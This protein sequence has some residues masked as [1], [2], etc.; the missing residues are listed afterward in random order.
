MQAAFEQLLQPGMCVYDVGANVG[1]FSVIAARLVGPEGCVI[2]FEPLPANARQIERNADLNHLGHIQVQT[3]ALGR[4]DGKVS[5]LV[6]EV[7]AWGKLATAGCPNKPAGEISIGVRRIDTIVEE[8]RI[9]KPDLIKIDVEGAEADVLAGAFQTLALLRPV[10]LI[11]LHGTNLQ[12]ARALSESNYIG[13]VLGSRSTIQ[14]ARWDAQIIGLPV[15]NTYFDDP[16]ARLT[17]P[18]H[19]T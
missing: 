5:F 17:S 14:D 16:I 11:E 13:H 19:C 12:V 9:R 7:S 15:E 4:E 10:L 1:F 3:E 6:S 2:S 8:G 18:N